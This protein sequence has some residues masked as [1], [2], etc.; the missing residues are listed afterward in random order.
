MSHGARACALLLAL[1]ATAAVAQL[2][3]IPPQAKRAAMSHVE[4][5]TVTLDGDRAQ[6]APGAQIRG[7]TNLIVLPAALPPGSRVKYTLDGE[8]QVKQVWI[9][10]PQEAAQP[11]PKP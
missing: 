3:S 8:G 9:L 6:L 11:D 7:P 10:S 5:M 2:R 4:G 1:G